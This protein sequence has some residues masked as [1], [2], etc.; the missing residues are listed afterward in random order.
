[1]ETKQS[2]SKNVAKTFLVIIL[3]IAVIISLSC[4]ALHLN[5][6]QLEGKIFEFAEHHYFLFGFISFIIGMIAVRAYM[7]VYIE[8]SRQENKVSK[9]LNNV[10]GK[11]Y[12]FTDSIKNDSDYQFIEKNKIENLTFPK[13]DVLNSPEEIKIREVALV[14]SM[15]LGNRYTT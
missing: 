6:L 5:P 9:A 1:M 8:V 14:Q 13:E 11:H 10:F 4:L 15:S 7:M 2:I 3:S 12:E